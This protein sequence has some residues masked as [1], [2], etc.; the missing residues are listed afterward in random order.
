VTS[1]LRTWYGRSAELTAWTT[2]TA[3]AASPASGW[4]L[5]CVAW[6]CAEPL[7]AFTD[8]DALFPVAPGTLSDEDFRSIL[9][10]L[11]QPIQDLHEDP[12]SFPLNLTLGRAYARLAEHYLATGQTGLTRPAVTQA[13]AIRDVLVA[14]DPKSP[15]VLNFKRRVDA[16]EHTGN[17]L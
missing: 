6:F 4:S 1:R 7:T 8:R 16:L 2:R 12:R 13:A 5:S 15:V 11:S 17:P 9:S 10:R 3:G 14:G